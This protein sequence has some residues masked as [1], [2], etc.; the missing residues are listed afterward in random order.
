MHDAI[1]EHWDTTGS[2]IGALIEV[3]HALGPG[4]LESAYEECLCHELALRN[5]PFE[6]QRAVPFHYKD[7]EVEVGFRIDV[8]VA[9]TILVEL[10]SVA[11]LLPIHIA[12]VVT[13]LRLSAIPVALLVNFNVPALRTGLR[14]ISLSSRRAIVR[15]GESDA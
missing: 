13:Y 4:L 1:H 15:S 12:Q 5:L 9:G 2:V 11:Q 3:H 10:K 14:R 7:I 8:V 6:R